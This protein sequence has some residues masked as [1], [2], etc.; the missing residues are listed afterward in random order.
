MEECDVVHLARR[1]PPARTFAPPGCRGRFR[2]RL[3]RRVR[4]PHPGVRGAVALPEPGRGIVS[5]RS[6]GR[7]SAPDARRRR[8]VQIDACPPPFTFS[9]PRRADRWG[10]SFPGRSGCSL[11]VVATASR[12]SRTGA[13]PWLGERSP[14]RASRPSTSTSCRNGVRAVDG[15][16]ED[17]DVF[18]RNTLSIERDDLD[19]VLDAVLAG[20]LD[21]PLTRP[22]GLMGHSR[23]GGI[24]LLGAAERPEVKALVTWAA[25]RTSTGSPTRRTT[26]SERRRT[27]STRSQ[28]RTGQVLR[29]GSSFDD[30]LGNRAAS[31]F[32]GRPAPGHLRRSSF[33]A[34][35]TR[36]SVRGSRRARRGRRQAGASR[37]RRGRGPHV[38]LVHPFAGRRRTS[39]RRC[40]DLN[41]L[42]GAPGSILHLIGTRPRSGSCGRLR[43]APNRRRRPAFVRG[44]RPRPEAFRWRARSILS[45]RR[46]WWARL[47][48]FSERR[49]R[50]RRESPVGR[51]RPRPHAG[52]ASTAKTPPLP[53]ATSRAIRETGKRHSRRALR[54]VGHRRGSPLGMGGSVERRGTRRGSARGRRRR[55]R[56]DWSSNGNRRSGVTVG[57]RRPVLAE[58]EE[59]PRPSGR[60]RIRTRCP[61]RVS[62]SVPADRG[63]D[64]AE[65]KRRG[66]SARRGGPLRGA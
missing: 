52:G 15:D 30:V 9:A 40:G 63:F 4:H 11:V 18:R 3:A 25:C 54:F 22:A 20:R 13:S 7:V 16:I 58:E 65:R 35:P 66:S 57:R 50:A 23:G 38:R 53:A 64:R 48:A 41:H 60:R 49:F 43:T 33:T 45:R 39:S 59:P 27:G 19:T 47:I 14:P 34:P 36:R 56:W 1:A 21:A 26:L 61:A 37:G 28:P 24:A 55:G 46:R 2:R 44:R 12:A 51:G 17:L 62:R 32:S 31:T 29:L 8:Q 5:P 42:R 10:P 6:A